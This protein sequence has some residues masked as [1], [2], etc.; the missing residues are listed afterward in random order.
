[1]ISWLFQAPNTAIM[2]IE[3][4]SRSLCTRIYDLDQ[5]WKGFHGRSN[6]I[7]NHQY[8]EIWTKLVNLIQCAIH[9]EATGTK[10]R[11]REHW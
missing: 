8:G 5:I 9:K 2:A 7:C 4:V 10:N 6:Q 3:F 11:V 1:M